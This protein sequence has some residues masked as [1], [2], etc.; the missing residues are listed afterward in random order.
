MSSA[1]TAAVDQ[2]IPDSPLLWTARPQLEYLLN[3][4][5]EPLA[6]WSRVKRSRLRPDRLLS[7]VAQ[8]SL[9]PDG[10]LFVWETLNQRRAMGAL[11]GAPATAGDAKAW[12]P[13]PI[14]RTQEVSETFE[15]V[16]SKVSLVP[17]RAL[18]STFEHT[19]RQAAAHRLLASSV[20]DQV[21]VNRVIC[22][23]QHS[24]LIRA[25]L[26]EARLRKVPTVYIPHAPFARSPLYAD[27]P[28][29][30]ALL[31]GPRE[32]AEYVA[33]GGRSAQMAICGAPSIPQL[34]PKGAS[35]EIVVAPSP[36]SATA[37]RHLFGIVDEAVGPNEY[38][39]AL[40]PRLGRLQLQTAI[41][42]S[43][44]LT[45]LR[46]VEHLAEQ[47]GVLIQQSSG[48]ALEAMLLGTPVIDIALSAGGDSAYPVI[49]EPHVARV[50]DGESLARALRDPHLHNR[51]RLRQAAE[52]AQEWCSAL[53]DQA[54]DTARPLI[55]ATRAVPKMALDGW[56]ADRSS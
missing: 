56:G 21:T 37:L 24:T 17:P 51:E 35:R 30:R 7:G 31:R 52:W 50:A 5:D 1:L 42:H 14:R 33:L 54:D 6:I 49:A 47:G 13:R 55:A 32:V 9:T 36:R 27:L 3:L 28:V 2:L 53:G 29:D 34:T 38:I 44:R 11:P 46:T 10:D 22:S 23:T 40:H 16:V 12:R 15:R 48:V 20:F 18:R 45:K 8:T 4:G 25:F 41:R 26:M 43:V 39:V 19:I